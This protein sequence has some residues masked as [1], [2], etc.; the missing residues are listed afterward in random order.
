MLLGNSVKKKHILQ[1]SLQVEWFYDA[2]LLESDSM[3]LKSKSKKI[4]FNK[5]KISFQYGEA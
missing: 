1:R 2:M 3:L 4:F 5:L